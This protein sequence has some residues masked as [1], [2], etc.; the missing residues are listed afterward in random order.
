[1]T[2]DVIRRGEKTQTENPQG[3]C[4]VMM[5]AELERCFNKPKGTKTYWQH[6]KLKKA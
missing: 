2:G 5:E 4:F 6:Q 1:M 3:E